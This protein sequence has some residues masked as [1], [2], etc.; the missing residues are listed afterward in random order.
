MEGEQQPL[1]CSKRSPSRDSHHNLM[2]RQKRT[3]LLSSRPSLRRRAA[4][5]GCCLALA[6]GGGG[7]GGRGGVARASWIDPDTL[8]EYHTKDYEGDSRDF[9]LVFSDEFNRA[10]RTFHDGQDPRWT[11]VNKNDYTNKALQFYSNDMCKTR[12]GSLVVTANNT[13]IEFTYYDTPHKKFK[14]MKKTYVSGMLQSWNKFCFTG[15]TVEIRAILPGRGDVGG[16][17][18]AMWLMGNLARATYT[19]SS[20]FTWP[21]SYNKCNRSTEEQ[22]GWQK[23]QEISACDSSVHYGLHPNTG[24]GAPEIDMMETMGGDGVGQVSPGTPILERPTEGRIPRPGEW[25]EKGIVYGQNS[26]VNKWFY[27]VHLKHDRPEKSYFSDAVSGNHALSATHFEEMH[28]FRLDWQP[29]KEE[30]GTKGY[31]R[32]YLDDELLYGI[33]DDTLGSFRGSQIP[34]EPVYLILNTAISSTWGFPVCKPGCACDCFDASDPACECAVDPEFYGLFPAEFVIDHVRVYQARNDSS[35]TVG[36]D[37]K[38]Y[39]TRDFILANHERYKDPSDDDVMLPVQVGG[40][41]CST[42]DDCNGNECFEGKKCKCT[43][44]WTGPQCRAAAASDDYVY[45]DHAHERWPMQPPLVPPALSRLF[46]LLA[47]AFA[48]T[49]YVRYSH[50]Q[51]RRLYATVD[52]SGLTI[53][54]PAMASFR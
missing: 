11:A 23:Q 34:L 1:C 37:T 5:L 20:D 12:N 50:R 25:Y 10:D 24:R 39:P 26:S 2:R 52:S 36:C 19:A 14:T 28:T 16:L 15:G 47:A 13:E 40:G 41:S 29:G 9:D 49:L 32:W 35:H 33:D 38:E 22:A 44:M 21:W 45:Q 48:V 42:S 18:P 3:R 27:G 6:H 43:D 7:R 30:D 54:P 17:W 31:L 51:K 4:A 8:A 46:A 53:P